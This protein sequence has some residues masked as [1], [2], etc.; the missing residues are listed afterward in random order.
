MNVNLRV[1]NTFHD[2]KTARESCNWIIR[3]QDSS[4]NTLPDNTLSIA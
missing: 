3:Q 2:N 4:H 1:L